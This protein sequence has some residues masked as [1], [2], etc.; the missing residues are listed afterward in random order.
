LIP[1]LTKALQELHAENQEYV[2]RIDKLEEELH[3]IKMLL[4]EE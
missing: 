4:T 1:I 2:S 3:A